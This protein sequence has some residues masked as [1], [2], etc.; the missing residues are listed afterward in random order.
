MPSVAKERQRRPEPGGQRAIGRCIDAH[1]PLGGIPRLGDEKRP[2]KEVC[3]PEIG[4]PV[5]AGPQELP[6]SPH[7]QILFGDAKSVPGPDHHSHAP[8]SV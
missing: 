4:Q 3:G 8:G 6:R 5:L 1:E 2:G 7:G